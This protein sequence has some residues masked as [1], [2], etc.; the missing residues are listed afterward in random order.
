MTK[1]NG[2]YKSLSRG[3]SQQTPEHRLD[4]Q[5]E[6]QLNMLT[7]PVTGLARRHGARFIAEKPINYYGAVS[8]FGRLRDALRGLRVVDYSI[9]D[10]EYAVVYPSVDTPFDD[11]FPG[12]ASVMADAISVY[13]KTPLPGAADGSFIP[14]NLT[15]P[16]VRA[17]F[18]AGISSVTQIGRFLLLAPRVTVTQPPQEDHWGSVANSRLAAVWVRGGAYAR[19]FQVTV[20]L[21]GVPYTATHTT[22]KASYPGVLDTSDIPYA[23]PNY[24]KLVNDRV[25]AYNSA[26]TAWIGTSG[27][28]VQPPAIAGALVSALNTAVGV[29]G[30]FFANGAHILIAYTGLDAI[31]VDDGGDG[32]LLRAVHQTVKSAELVSD[33]HYAGKVVRVQADAGSPAY[34]LKSTSVDGVS[35]TGPMRWE[36]TAQ[37]SA[38]Y[39]ASPLLIGTVHNG[40][41]YFS[42]S[43]AALR[44]ALPGVID[45]LPDF[46]TRLIGDLVTSTDPQFLN[47]RITYI[48]TFQDRLIV[49]AGSVVCM[50][51][52]GNYFNFYRT[53]SLTVKDSDPV[54][55]YALGAEDDTIRYSVIFDKSLLLF[56]DRRQYSI[57]GRVPVT[58]ATTTVIQSSAVEGATDTAP[59]AVGDLVFFAKRKEDSSQLYQIAIGDVQDTS[60]S[61]DVGAQLADYLPG[62]PMELLATSSP[63]LVLMRC[64]SAP[65]AVYVF[66]YVDAGRER[67]LDSWSCFDYGGDFGEIFG[68][69]LHD[70]QVLLF[71]HREARPGWP[72][73]DGAFGWISVDTQPLLSTVSSVPYL[74]SWRPITALTGGKASRSW[75]NQPWL[76]AAVSR[77]SNYWLYGAKGAP[78]ALADLRTDFPD[79]VTSAVV[80]GL[81]YTSEVMLTSP[82]RRDNDGKPL[83][84][85][86]T[87]NRVDVSVKDS[88]P[89][90]YS[91]LVPDF[92]T[93]TDKVAVR[94]VGTQSSI[95]GRQPVATGAVPVFVGRSARDYSLRLTATDW[96]P[97]TLTSIEWTGQWFSNVRRA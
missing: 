70:D 81:E 89:F 35:S 10:Q 68:M 58:S 92:P 49:A 3:V 42:E 59:V 46:N 61:S 53:S 67:V 15:S 74:D 69:L 38:P 17:E 27:A 6:A 1:I 86:L 80:A 71:S 51:E 2:V 36:E 79:L 64:Y 13:R 78:T 41:M 88:G 73:A 33:L 76:S 90:V 97:F 60:N 19:K 22:P 43:P 30:L 16:Q 94:R 55:V 75:W 66:R 83:S 63:N 18:A 7:D 95:V 47:R 50:S 39:M 34:Y 32:T 87:V 93:A 44:L 20:T 57:D 25:N 54:E 45:D 28:A 31:S 62:R 14:V 72:G 29:P 5:H 77:N 21:N 40:T 84:G 24:T 12:T 37:V 4:G 65:T 48:S 85:R 96:Q 26:V 9:E 8:Q 91:V 56:G 11:P 82:F 23:D 52:T